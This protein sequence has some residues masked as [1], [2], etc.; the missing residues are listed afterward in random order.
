MLENFHTGKY[1]IKKVIS[2]YIGELDLPPDFCIYL[3]FYIKLLELVATNPSHL[4]Y[5][6]PLSLLIEVDRKIKYKVLA[7]VNFHLFGRAKKLQYHIQ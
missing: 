5:M 6:Q 2:L 7:I 1:P 4:G 3:V